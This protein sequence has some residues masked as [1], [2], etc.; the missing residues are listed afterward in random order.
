MR[1]PNF[2]SIRHPCSEPWEHQLKTCSLCSAR[3]LRDQ[4]TRSTETPDN[5]RTNGS[6]ILIFAFPDRKREK[7]YSERNDNKHFEFNL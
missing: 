7:K 6:Y 4:F 3:S 5:Y 2:S 1:R